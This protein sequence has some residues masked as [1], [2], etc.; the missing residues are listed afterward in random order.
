[1]GKIIAFSGSHGTGKTTAAHALMAQLKV[2]E[3]GIDIGFLGEVARRCPYPINL[4]GCVRGQLWIFCEQI[5]QELE[6]MRQHDL[7]VADRC[8]LDSIAYTYHHGF[9]MAEA[10]KDLYW[11][12]LEKEEPYQEIRFLNPKPGYLQADGLREVDPSF[13]TEVHEILKRLH[14]ETGGPLVWP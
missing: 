9:D 1:M 2:S 11:S 8:L 7:V 5:K 14:L 6:L 10:M 13:Q 4:D 3:P 12:Y